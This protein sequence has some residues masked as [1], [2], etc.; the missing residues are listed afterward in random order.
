MTPYSRYF[1]LEDIQHLKEEKAKKLQTSARQQNALSPK[2]S[3]SG[4]C[5]KYP[6]QKTFSESGIDGREYNGDEV[7]AHK[8]EFPNCLSFQK[9]SEL[10]LSGSDTVHVHETEN[11]N[12]G[13]TMN[14]EA[15]NWCRCFEQKEP[16]TSSAHSNACSSTT[17]KPPNISKVMSLEEDIPTKIKCKYCRLEIR[18][19][20]RRKER[21]IELWMQFFGSRSSAETD[22]QYC[23]SI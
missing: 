1:S 14:N 4:V 18:E 5:I 16:T 8:I 2:E 7:L 3:Q 20:H 11:C 23:S 6:T 21:I 15:R 17:T 12:E 9:K 22:A 13:F 19:E 10:Q